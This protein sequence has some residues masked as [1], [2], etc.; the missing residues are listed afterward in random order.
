MFLCF[1]DS[2][3]YDFVFRFVSSKQRYLSF[4]PSFLPYSEILLLL[5]VF[6]F[7]KKSEDFKNNSQNSVKCNIDDDLILKENK[8]LTVFNNNP[9]K[10]RFCLCKYRIHQHFSVYVSKHVWNKRKI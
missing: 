9:H 10:T 5:Q 2:H 4:I 6:W 1:H 8:K 3:L 7:R